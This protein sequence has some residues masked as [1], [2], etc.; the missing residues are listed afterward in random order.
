MTKDK[1]QKSA[2]KKTA[3]GKRGPAPSF[4]WFYVRNLYVIEGMTLADIAQL[5]DMPAYNT[6]TARSSR[7]SWA[8]QRADY[9]D[10]VQQETIKSYSQR[11]ASL[12]AV[13]LDIAME[14]RRKAL[15][16]LRLIDP[17]KMTANDVRQMLRDAAEMERKATGTDN[18][19]SM[20]ELRNLDQQSDEQILEYAAK[21][22]LLGDDSPGTDS[23]GIN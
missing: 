19:I 10:K 5:P 14:M 23:P 6:L 18:I 16:G 2:G 13:H 17:A 3:A 15:E 22:G 12:K 11:E 20:R 1:P 4:N 7:E 21:L 8:Q 9:R